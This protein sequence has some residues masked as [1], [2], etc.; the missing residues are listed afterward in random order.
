MMRSFIKIVAV[1]R[2]NLHWV[3]KFASLW[4]G[5]SLNKLLDR[6]IQVDASGSDIGRYDTKH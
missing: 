2:K 1:M 6:I 3:S 4:N 5:I